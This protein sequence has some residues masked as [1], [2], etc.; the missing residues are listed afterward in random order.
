MIFQQSLTDAS[1]VPVP[2]GVEQR[3]CHGGKLALTSVPI[4]AFERDAKLWKDHKEM[5][6]SYPRSFGNTESPLAQKT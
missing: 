4:C 6:L 2:Y 1:A 3:V 5:K